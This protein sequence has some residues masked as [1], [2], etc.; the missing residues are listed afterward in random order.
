MNLKGV[1]TTVH[2]RVCHFDG[3]SFWTKLF[4]KLFLTWRIFDEKLP[5]FTPIYG[6]LGDLSWCFSMRFFM[7]SYSKMPIY[8]NDNFYQLSMLNIWSVQHIRGYSCWKI[9]PIKWHTHQGK[10]KFFYMF[11]EGQKYFRSLCLGLFTPM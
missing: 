6:F 11:R 10:I 2:S 5:F 9:L 4:G 3:Q 1:F 8:K 7:L